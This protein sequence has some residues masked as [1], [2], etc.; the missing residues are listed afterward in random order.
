[1]IFR[2]LRQM[3]IS[4]LS[5]L[6]PLDNPEVLRDYVGV[7]DAIIV[8]NNLNSAPWTCIEAQFRKDPMGSFTGLGFRP[9]R[10]GQI[11]GFWYQ[12]GLESNTTYEFQIRAF[13][14]AS[15]RYSAWIGL[16]F[17]TWP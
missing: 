7:H 6:G 13:D 8:V 3:A 9:W 12:D 2:F 16:S 15:G 17:T 14:Q 4:V 1:M 10:Q 5:L 11:Y